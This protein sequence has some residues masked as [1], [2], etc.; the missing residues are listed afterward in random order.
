[1]Q[2]LIISDLHGETA[3]LEPLET[4]IENKSFGV[5]FFCGDIVKGRE[6]GNEWRAA[7]KEGREPNKEKLAI[8]TEKDEDIAY[9]QKFYDF[10]DRTNIITFTIPGNMDAP[11][12]RYLKTLWHSKKKNINLAHE[13]IRFFKDM[14]ICG[15]GGEI[16]EEEEETFFVLKYPRDK[17]IFALRKLGYLKKD[18]VLLTHNPPVCDL[19]DKKGSPA[20]NEIIERYNPKFLFCGHAHVQGEE[21]INE[22]LVVNPGALKKGEYATINF[23]TGQVEFNHI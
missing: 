8:I 5:I 12:S 17:V 14:A 13:M 19:A 9:Y 11:E 20:I 21:E 7:K 23:N 2:G 4:I 3:V 6:R 1:M 10:L 15:F 16:N 18:I 22:T